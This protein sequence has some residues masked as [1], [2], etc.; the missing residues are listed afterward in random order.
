MST[1]GKLISEAL[2]GVLRCAEGHHF[3]V[4]R[5]TPSTMRVIDPEHPDDPDHD[6][7]IYPMGEVCPHP[8]YFS[9]QERLSK[10]VT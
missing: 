4:Q 5:G 1:C 10:A 2:E 7:K 3:R 8:S 6:G 9:G